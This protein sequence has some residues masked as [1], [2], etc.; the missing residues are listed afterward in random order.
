MQLAGI[1]ALNG[2]QECVKELSAV[3]ERRMKK[4]VHGL[5]KI[6]WN[7]K[8]TKATMYVW[9]QLPECLKKEGSLAFGERL[10]KETGVVV[11]PGVGFGKCGEGY[12]RMSLVTHDRRFHDALLRIGKVTKE[13]R[14]E[15]K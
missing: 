12:V 3:Y 1:A 7:V 14:K 5:N 15:Q 6:G 10:V 13:A 2:S 9:A 11:S 8:E 4:V